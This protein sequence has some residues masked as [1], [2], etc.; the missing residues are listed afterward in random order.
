MRRAIV[1]WKIQKSENIRRLK[2]TLLIVNS[3]KMSQS[4]EDATETSYL[5]PRRVL[6]SVCDDEI[7]DGEIISYIKSRRESQIPSKWDAIEADAGPVITGSM[8]SNVGPKN[9]A[10]VARRKSTSTI[11]EII[12]HASNM[13]LEPETHFLLEMK[14]M[15][16]NTA[17]L[18]VTF[19]LQ[20][21]LTVTS[22]F[23]V[24]HLG[25]DA[26]GAVSLASMT[27]NITGYALIEGI[28]ASLDTLCSQAYGRKDMQAVGVHFVRCTYLLL[29]LFIPVFYLWV[30]KSEAVILYL[31]GEENRELSKLASSYLRITALGIPGFI[32]FENA[33]HFL[34][35]QGIFHAS[36]YVLIFAAP[37]N[38]LLSYVLVWNK[39][40]GMGFIGAPIAVVIADWFMCIFIF[41]YI[42][43]VNGYQCLP[44]ASLFSKLYFTNWSSMVRLSIA[45]VLVVESEWF[46]FEVLTFF[47]ST[48]GKEALAAQSILTTTCV[49]MYQIPFSL[50]IVASTRIGWFIGAAAETSA[51]IATRVSLLI[52]FV[53]GLSSALMLYV[54]KNFIISL[55]TSDP[56]VHKLAAKV[57]VI[58]S[59]YQINDFVT[60]VANGILRGQGR[61]AIG[62]VL[63]VV[64]YYLIALP[65]AFAFSHYLNMNLIGLWLGM[66]IALW[67]ISVGEVYFVVR[68]DWL[69]IIDKS[70]SRGVLEHRTGTP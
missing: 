62:G 17:P 41:W 31:I 21:S 43:Y 2:E 6:E 22:V 32:L 65:S 39:S 63:N 47:A 49:L 12:S 26:L 35:S 38:V 29:L 10:A 9:E 24:G 34:Q 23:S 27:A 7:D 1:G 44:K 37:L 64:S 16:R 46:A 67:V 15:I 61:Q 66:L 3:S 60:C 59:L 33:K 19:L 4:E 42:F 69:A 14:T 45:N 56:I 68:S 55:Y 8:Q 51:V 25:L 70:V 30:F 40:V 28:A 57:L 58:A 53:G 54:L 20:Y 48:F 11:G 52:S 13:P 36:T 5:L 50:S 18:V